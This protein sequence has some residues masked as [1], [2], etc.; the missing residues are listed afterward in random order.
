M[1]LLSPKCLIFSNLI[2]LN[3][4]MIISLNHSPSLRVRKSRALV[5]NRSDLSFYVQLLVSGGVCLALDIFI[6]KNDVSSDERVHLSL[7]DEPDLNSVAITQSLGSA[8][9]FRFETL[10]RCEKQIDLMMFLGGPLL[11]L[12]FISS[13]EC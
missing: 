6:V 3:A 5:L 2:L 12:T 9:I 7:F 8:D 1:N 4:S 10:N 13:F 11:G